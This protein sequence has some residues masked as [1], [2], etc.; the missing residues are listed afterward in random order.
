MAVSDA[1]ISLALVSFSL[2]WSQVKQPFIFA[3][4]RHLPIESNLLQ[5]N[6]QCQVL[7]SQYKY[8]RPLQA[9]PLLAGLCL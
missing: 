9:G 2:C 4:R 7:F 5:S 1:I 8:F 3:N 6:R